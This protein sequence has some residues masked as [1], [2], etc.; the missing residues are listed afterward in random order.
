MPSIDKSSSKETINNLRKQY[1]EL[2]DYG[3]AHP[4]ELSDNV[5]KLRNLVLL[6]GL[7]PETSEEVENR[8]KGNVWCGMR[9]M[10]WKV[11][12]NIKT[13]DNEKYVALVQKGEPNKEVYQQIRKDVP[14]TFMSDHEFATCVPQEKLSRTL[15][16]FAHYCSESTSRL[17]NI[18]YVQGMNTL[19]APFLYILPEVDAFYAFGSFIL[20]H[21]YLYVVPNIQGVHTG[22]K[23]MDKI[24]HIVDP[25]LYRHL[26]NFNF[27]PEFLMHSILSLGTGTPPL[28]QVLHL[29]DFFFAFGIH[30][31]VVSTVA[32]LVLMRDTLLN[33]TSPCSVLRSLP[34]LQAQHIITLTV[35][36]VN[37]LPGDL[38]NMLA[39]HP[40]V[41]IQ[42]PGK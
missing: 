41:P 8:M 38:Y 10:V 31:N 24:L 13:V 42:I 23:L 9:G 22:L 6:H 12:L 37:Q 14:R 35:Q 17:S 11:L 27:N 39:A 26:H 28:D 3:N 4:N 33:H 1:M 2:L 40:T 21:C 29:W 5:A 15:S 34:P 30:L 32:Q 16:A 25:E 36:L 20:E 7:P 18:Q 19:M